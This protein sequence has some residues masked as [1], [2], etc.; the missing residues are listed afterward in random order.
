MRKIT[1]TNSLGT[2]IIL[3]DYVIGTSDYKLQQWNPERLNIESITSKGYQQDG[4][5]YKYEDANPRQIDFTGLAYS[6]DDAA[7]TEET[8]NTIFNPILGE[9][10]LKHEYGDYSREITVRVLGQP[11][12]P[13][14]KVDN[15]LTFSVIMQADYP[16]YRDLTYTEVELMGVSGGF[17]FDSP[18]FYFETGTTFTFGDISASS[19]VLTNL[20][21]APA[22]LYMEWTGV[23]TNPKLTLVDTGDFILLNGSLTSDQRLIITTGYGNKTVSIQTISTGVIVQDNSLVDDSSTYFSAPIGNSTISFSADSGGTTSVVTVKY[24]QLWL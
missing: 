16:F 13:T 11:I 14:A 19:G 17:E 23:A 18:S 22:P 10:T 24:K 6:Y 5:T 1:Y 2:S 21:H 8:L 7:D 12:I 20:G 3:K 15:S 4:V 9:G